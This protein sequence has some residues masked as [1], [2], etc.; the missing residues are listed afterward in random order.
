MRP[1]STLSRREAIGGGV[2][3][4]AIASTSALARPMHGGAAAPVPVG[5]PD[6]VVI[7]YNGTD[8]TYTL[9]G[10]TNMGD[11]IGPSYTQHSVRG[12]SASPLQYF[13]VV[14][15]NYADGSRWEVFF[16]LGMWDQ[17]NYFTGDVGST[18]QM[19]GTM[20]TAYT[21]TIKDGSTTLQTVNVPNH[22]WQARWYAESAPVPLIRTASDLI[23]MSLSPK[24]GTSGVPGTLAT[25]DNSI[26]VYSAPMDNG[27]IAQYMPM[28]GGR[29]DIGVFFDIGCQYIMSPS[30]TLENYIRINAKGGG[31]IPWHLR[32]SSSGACVDMVATPNKNYQN[33]VDSTS[34]VGNQSPNFDSGGPTS[35]WT[36]DVSHNPQPFWVMAALT[37]HSVFV[38]ELQMQAI[39]SY[40]S[41][42]FWNGANPRFNRQED[43]GTWWAG[44]RN[45]LMAWRATQLV[46]ANGTLP[47]WLRP[48]S[49]FKGILDQNYSDFNY[50][51][52][53][54]ASGARGGKGDY[55]STGPEMN[56]I[57]CWQQEF[58]TQ[59][60]CLATLFG[61]TNWA[62]A[63]DWSLLATKGRL[64]EMP[65]YPCPYYF[66]I[67]SVWAYQCKG[68][69]LPEWDTIKDHYLTNW[70]DA[71]AQLNAMDG[72]AQL[73]DATWATISA[74][75]TNGG[76][77]VT[78]YGSGGT[79][80]QDPNYVWLVRES[81]AFAVY[82]GKSSYASYLT[83][84]DSYITATTGAADYQTHTAQNAILSA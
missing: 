9:S 66:S 31:S 42:D 25:P 63:L 11:F 61:C 27:G 8:Y 53:D 38:E 28:T 2:A 49:Y 15:R 40:L 48:S 14:F 36:I 55:F 50:W 7:N 21:A 43:R 29:P 17:I 5:V 3:A 74:D 70:Y 78:A 30:P 47:G 16:E 45:L 54:P 23:S 51:F 19:H 58:R 22:W 64:D 76:K 33:N 46:E 4:A 60:L 68:P 10:G 44:L 57:G 79:A 41:Q 77:F 80:I 62:S 24:F 26:Y 69:D 82:V 35:G 84:F 6:N 1:V 18:Y 75:P 81:L 71:Y 65:C 37:E 73:P 34:I 83:S 52:F 12:H 32:E 67:T 39:F 56:A 72:P 13:D 20:G 59:V